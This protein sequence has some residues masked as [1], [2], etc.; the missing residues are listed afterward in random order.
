MPQHQTPHP[1][2][3]VG[4]GPGDPEL[5]TLRALNRIQ[6]ADTILHDR[7][8]PGAILDLAR[9]GARLIETGKTGF[10]ATMPQ[11]AINALM[12][13]E[14]HSGARLVRLKGGDP[15]V[16][17]RLDEELDALTAAGIEYEITPGITTASAAVASIGQSLTRRGRNGSAR[18]ITG[19]DMQGYADHDWRALAQP[20]SVAAIYM[21]K[22]AARF[23][24]GRLM[25]HGAAP[26]TP[27]T[28]IENASRANQRVLETTLE[29]LPTDLAAADFDGPAL[30]FLG[31]TPRQSLAALSDLNMEL[32]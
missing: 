26:D 25:M 24:Q 31:L 16:F 1:V 22:R 29:R 30:T 5:L 17:G 2:A 32:A 21:A 28:V 27:V 13:S 18:L 12:I 6:A 15:A 11:E 19:H 20:G 4:A 14:A 10:G 7:L 8:V 23:I 3:I 9:P